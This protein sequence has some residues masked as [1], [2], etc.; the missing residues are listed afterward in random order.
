M[1]EDFFLRKDVHTGEVLRS[2]EFSQRRDAIQ[3]RLFPRPGPTTR[4][5]G[6]GLIGESEPGSPYRLCLQAAIWN[7]LK[8]AE[9]LQSGESIWEFEHNGN[10]RAAGQAHG[11]YCV[12][13]ASLP[14]QGIWAHHV[15][16]KGLWLP[17]EKWIFGRLDIGCD[18]SRRGTLPWRQTI[19]YHLAQ[20]MDSLLDT[21]PWHAKAWVKR[22]M[23]LILGPLFQRS[24]RR[25]GHDPRDSDSRL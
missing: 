14:Y 21:L 1:L 10:V 8:L 12:W 15:V 3:V 23:K 17:E 13:R 7:R 25:L 19:F 16:E 9:L 11:F 18:F 20:R 5:S 24:L 2:L 4:L 6:E 22:R